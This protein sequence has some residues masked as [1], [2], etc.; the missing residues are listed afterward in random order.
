MIRENKYYIIQIQHL[1]KAIIKLI[2]L[3]YNLKPC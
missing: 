1:E 3:T 2:H